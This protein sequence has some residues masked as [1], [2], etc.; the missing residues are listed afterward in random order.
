MVIK[1]KRIGSSTSDFTQNDV[2]IVLAME[3]GS[4]VL[5]NDANKTSEVSR[6]ELNTS[7]LWLLDSIETAG[8]VRLYP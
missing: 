5:L 4:C 3:S 1:Y 2:Y 6:G 7:S 8:T